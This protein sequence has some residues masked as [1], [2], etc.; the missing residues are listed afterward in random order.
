[1][2]ALILRVDLHFV[3]EVQEAEAERLG[4]PHW[5]RDWLSLAA[6]HVLDHYSDFFLKMIL[7]VL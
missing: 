6:P 3:G 4:P 7:D 1:M 5:Q 2:K